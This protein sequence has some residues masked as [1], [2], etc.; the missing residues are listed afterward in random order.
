MDR[1]TSM[2]VFARVAT[3]RSFSAAARDLGLSQATVSKHVQTLESWFG[4]RLLNRT[5]RRVALTEVGADFFSQCTRILEDMDAALEARKPDARLRGSLR[6][7]AP[8]A[9]GST[10]L[11][12][13]L[14]EFMRQ[15]PD[16]A[17]SVAL[18]DRPV[19]VIEEGY[20]VAIRASQQTARD[21]AGL[22]VH[23]L[24]PLHF[25]LCAAPA[26]IEAH[27]QPVIPADLGAHVCL[28]DSRHPGDIWRFASSQGRVDVP[29]SGKLRCD[30][31]LLR[32]AAALDG[33][34]ILLAPEY[35]VSDDIAAGRLVALIPGHTPESSTID[36]L[37]PPARA[38]SPKVRT[39]V[40][41]LG[42]QL[43]G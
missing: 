35:M 24:A 19:D 38:T 37:C 30:N 15:N 6:I 41:F 12:G 11:P 2:T 28:T 32:R 23:A 21:D 34:G 22:V 1:L 26:Y 9:F 42:E 43:K 33:A 18:R 31:G 40:A 4:A 17:L 10:R 13:L 14:V 7:S 20:D 39:L 27:G 8:V 25:V 16:L 29:V 36:A 3:T 5:T